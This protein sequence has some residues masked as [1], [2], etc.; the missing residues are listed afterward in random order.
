MRGAARLAPGGAGLARV[1]T[2]NAEENRP[3]LDINEA[4]GF[5]PAAYEGAWKRTLEP[6]AG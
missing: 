4:I 6:A 3:M 5:R 1:V 2:Y